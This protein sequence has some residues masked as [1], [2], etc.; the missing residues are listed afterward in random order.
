MSTAKPRLGFVG[1]GNM[2]APMTNNLVKGGYSVTGFDVDRPRLLQR[3]QE[4]GFHAAES[5]IDCAR[6]SDIVITMLPNGHIVRDAALGANG[7]AEGLPKGS[8]IID[9][10]SAGATGT[11]ALGKELAAKGITLLDA[12]VSGGVTGAEAGTL[13]I[14]VGG[15]DEAAIE[16]AWPLLETMGK[17]LFRA[18]PL[19][20]GHA[21]KSINNYLGATNLIA[22]TEGLIAGTKFGLDP[23][24]L[25]AIINAS[26][27]SSGTSQGLFPGQVLN[28]KFGAGFA[29]ALMAKDV[30]LAAELAQDVGMNA[31]VI[32][33]T[34]K[35]WARARDTMPGN[36]DFTAIVQML[37]TDFGTELAPPKA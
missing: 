34:A 35:V 2:G 1:L 15:D 23:A 21:A 7:I 5:A 17:K 25:L 24:N 4:I 11:A 13:A 26:T 12:P 19:G 29:L 9:M 18:G 32:A 30:G 16:R 6:R 14:M 3:A 22:I 36:P 33:H 10:S 27:G 37:E 8:L 28:R 31:E 20:A